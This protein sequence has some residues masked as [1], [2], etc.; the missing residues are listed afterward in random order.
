MLVLQPTH[1]PNQKTS[2]TRIHAAFN[3]AAILS[4]MAAFI[5]IE[6]NKFD[7]GAPHFTSAHGRMGLVTYIIFLLQAIVGITQY[8]TPK[9]YGGEA[10]AKKIWK[11]H[12]MSGYGLLVLSLATI[13]AATQTDFNKTTYVLCF[14]CPC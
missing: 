10:Q 13:C 8:Y 1:T 12:R 7:H 9:L 11:Y 2:G 6:Y 3:S 5:I 4:L 14:S